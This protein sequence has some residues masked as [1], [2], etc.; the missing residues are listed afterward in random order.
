MLTDEMQ[1]LTHFVRKSSEQ[2]KT[3]NKK[4]NTKTKQAERSAKAQVFQLAS[5][6]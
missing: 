5:F 6:L 4:Q 3:K 2:L 1:I